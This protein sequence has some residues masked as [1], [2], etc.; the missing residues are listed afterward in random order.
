MDRTGE[1]S[2]GQK[3]EWGR[4]HVELMWDRGTEAAYYLGESRDM[5]SEASNKQ[6]VR[7]S[8]AVVG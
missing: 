6:G 3:G 4:R 1:A 7:L 5:P 8:W 2:P